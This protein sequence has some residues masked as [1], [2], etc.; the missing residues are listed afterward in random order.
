[1]ENHECDDSG[2]RGH[3]DQIDLVESEVGAGDANGCDDVD[4]LHQEQVDDD[5]GKGVQGDTG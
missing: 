1:M 4:L 3:E 5:L 2:I